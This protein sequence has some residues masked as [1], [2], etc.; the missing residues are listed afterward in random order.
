MLPLKKASTLVGHAKDVPIFLD[1]RFYAGILGSGLWLVR[2]HFVYFP[3]LSPLLTHAKTWD[4]QASSSPACTCICDQER[5]VKIPPS[6][7]GDGVCIP[8]RQAGMGCR[9]GGSA[10][11]APFGSQRAQLSKSIPE[12]PRVHGDQPIHHPNEEKLIY[13]PTAGTTY[14]LAMNDPSALSG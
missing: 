14:S 7:Y 3:Y 5:K 13:I 8:N 2:I 1:I 6:A 10:H 9:A 4:G 12:L 11:L